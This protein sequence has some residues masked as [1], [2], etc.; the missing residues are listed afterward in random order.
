MSEWWLSSCLPTFN[1]IKSSGARTSSWEIRCLWVAKLLC[2]LSMTGLR[3]RHSCSRR[4]SLRC[5]REVMESG[6]RLNSWLAS[7]LSWRWLKV[8]RK[9]QIGKRI[10][11][12]MRGSPSTNTFASMQ[13]TPNTSNAIILIRKSKRGLDWILL[14]RSGLSSLL[15]S[16]KIHRTSDRCLGSTHMTRHRSLLESSLAL[17][18]T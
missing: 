10:F 5:R 9:T 2:I 15:K 6:A 13:R 3:S 4:K 7:R 17:K 11:W 16:T 8:K 18:S 12:M 1:A 14:S